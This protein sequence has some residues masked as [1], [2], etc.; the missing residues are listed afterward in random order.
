MKKLLF[1][2]LLLS[3]VLSNAQIV[4]IPDPVFKNQLLQ[5][6]PGSIIAED[7]NGNYMTIDINGDGEIQFTEAQAVMKLQV[8]SSEPEGMHPQIL[9]LE[10]IDSF[11][12]LQFLSCFGNKLTELDVTSLINLR[13]LFV[14]NN[15]LT[16]L[17]VNGLVNLEKILC[18]GNQLNNLT[19]SGLFNLKELRASNNQLSSIDVSELLDL[20]T[21]NLSNNPISSINLQSSPSMEAFSCEGCPL[22]S[23]DLG[24]SPDLHQI[25]VKGCPLLENI[26]LKNGKMTAQPQYCDFSNCPNLKYICMDDGEELLFNNS[27]PENVNVNSYCSFEPGGGYNAVRGVVFFDNEGDGCDDND[28]VSHIKVILTGGN[29]TRT[30]ASNTSSYNFYTGDGDF[31]VSPD[32]NNE[33]FTVTPPFAEFAFTEVNNSI[34]EQNFCITPNG[35]HPDLDIVILPSFAQ[36]GFDADYKII[37]RN[38]GNQTL[39]GDIVFTYQEDVMDLIVATPAQNISSAGS[40]TWDYNSLY[41]FEQREIFVRFNVNGPTETPA[42]N[43]DDQLNFTVAVTPLTG[44]ETPGDNTFELNQIVTGSFDPNDI[45]CLQGAYVHPDKIGDYLHYNI[46]F[47][48]TGTAAATFIVVKDMID[49]TQFDIASLQ[50]LN[51]SHDVDVRIQDNKVEFMFDD[52]NL[53]ALGKGNVLFKIKTLNT[54]SANDEVTQKADIFFDYNSPVETNNAN[55]T[56]QVL[57]RNGFQI[58]NSVKLYPNPSGGIVTI[59]ADT[60]IKSIEFYDVQ[61]RLLQSGTINRNEAVFDITRRNSGLYFLKIITENGSKVE[62]V[63]KQ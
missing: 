5:A 2:V 59:K 16:S 43:I 21:L 30:S 47:E 10:G 9:S 41:P 8:I 38:K 20:N 14:H 62:K 37:Y 35:V 25:R 28:I 6:G 61:G 34:I 57:S 40:L 48:N 42:I 22:Q 51:A 56:F 19:V 29:I 50:L 13:T 12:N 24:N 27:I 23:I 52:I 39:S 18:D 46:N 7:F 17:N 32:F 11:S 63:I 49:I 36:P 60:L 1:F 55:T 3:A 53:P 54:L 58:D 33:F 4:T 31:T 45:T 44:D 26:N 15:D